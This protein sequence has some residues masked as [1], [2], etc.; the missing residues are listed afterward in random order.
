MDD[1]L[2]AKL[3]EFDLNDPINENEEVQEHERYMYIPAV[4]KDT[5]EYVCVL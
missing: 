3:G 2:S 1:P 4:T 5:L